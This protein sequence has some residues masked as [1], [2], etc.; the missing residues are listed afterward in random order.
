[1][2]AGGPRYTGC[3]LTTSDELAA[4]HVAHCAGWPPAVYMRLAAGPLGWLVRAHE[5]AAPSRP[6]TAGQAGA[7]QLALGT[8][9]RWPWL[10]GGGAG[11][12]A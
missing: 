6:G 4:G 1:M 8:G 7:M 2:Q 11:V 10:R 12:H 5:L 3:T 9:G